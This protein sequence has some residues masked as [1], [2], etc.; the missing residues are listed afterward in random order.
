MPLKQQKGLL[1]A[2]ARAGKQGVKNQLYSIIDGLSSQYTLTV[3]LTEGPGD[4][5]ETA[6]QA[7]GYDAVFVSG[8][9]GT[10]NGVVGG[11]YRAGLSIPIG[12]F[13]SGTAND[14]ATTLG[15]SRDVNK[16]LEIIRDGKPTPHDIG[17]LGDDYRFVYTA[18]FGAFTKVSYATSQK[19]KNMLGHMAYVLSGASELFKL[20]PERLTVKWDDGEL[21]DTDVLFFAVMNTHSMAG[22]VKIPADRIDLADGV[23]DMLVI[24]K[25]KTV[26]ET[27]VLLMDL[28]TNNLYDSK[29]ENV[30]FAHST[31]MEVHT[32]RPVA[33]TVDGEGTKEVSDTVVRVIPGGAKFIR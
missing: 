25:P 29:N 7:E 21:C 20:T 30:I 4:A 17:S 33:W 26:G 19:M 28:L 15:L 18:S 12:Y 1:I 16:T 6:Q 2:N 10:V 23:L 9:D 13:P 31:T 32:E 24:K 22:M 8:G 14:L 11:L 27:A 5:C 3:H